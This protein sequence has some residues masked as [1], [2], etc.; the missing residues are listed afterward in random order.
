M[1][2]GVQQAG[3]RGGLWE[4]GGFK[5]RNQKCAAWDKLF[6]GGK[7]GQGHILR[8]GDFIIL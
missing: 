8:D 4:Q 1:G 7:A 6:A 5:V 3:V 2:S